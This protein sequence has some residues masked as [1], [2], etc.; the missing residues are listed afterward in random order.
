MSQAEAEE[1]VPKGGEVVESA[2]ETVQ[3]LDRTTAA[4]P[5]SGRDPT[6]DP[7]SNS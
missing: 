6:S 7:D 3:E 5:V 1:R 2:I 4:E